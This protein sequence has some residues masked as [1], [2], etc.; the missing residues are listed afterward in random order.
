MF[1]KLKSRKL[2]VTIVSTALITVGQ[3]LGIPQEVSSQI[4]ALAVS[5]IVGQGVVDALN[6]KK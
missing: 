2:W 3:T 6:T 1:A 4:V 5:Y